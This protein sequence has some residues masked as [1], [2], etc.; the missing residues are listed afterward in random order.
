MSGLLGSSNEEESEMVVDWCRRSA[1]ISGKKCDS[2]GLRHG[3]MGMSHGFSGK[4]TGG[5]GWNGES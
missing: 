5:M 4:G 2:K 1:C 3:M